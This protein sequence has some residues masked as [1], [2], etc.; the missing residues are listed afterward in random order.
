MSSPRT[1]PEDNQDRHDGGAPESDDT[2]A[3]PGEYVNRYETE[4]D[5]WEDGLEAVTWDIALGSLALCVKVGSFVLHH[6]LMHVCVW[7]LHRDFLAPLSPIYA[8]E[9]LDLA[10]HSVSYEDLEV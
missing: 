7:Q 2:D 6:R 1:S 8:S 9:F 5:D 10:Y 3:V 4:L